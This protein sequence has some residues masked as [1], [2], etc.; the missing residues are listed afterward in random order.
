MSKTIRSANRDDIISVPKV[1]D[2]N[3]LFITGM[4]G[5][6]RQ[7]FKDKRDKRS[8]DRKNSWQRD[9]QENG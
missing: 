2:R 1:K 7:V 4:P 9:Y 8:K 3:P 6:G 5:S